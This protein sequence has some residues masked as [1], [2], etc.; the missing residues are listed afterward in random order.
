MVSIEPVPLT[1]M[2]SERVHPVIALVLDYRPVIQI[3]E[4]VLQE[5]LRGGQAA[6]C[7]QG[8]NTA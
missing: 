5:A 1:A 8:D 2:Q 4:P 6:V 7:Q 3:H